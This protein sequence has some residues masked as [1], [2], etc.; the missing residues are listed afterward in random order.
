MISLWS[1][2][3][4]YIFIC[5]YLIVPFSVR[6]G[7]ISGLF[8][9]AM[10]ILARL[11]SRGHNKNHSSTKL[12]WYATKVYHWSMVP[13]RFDSNRYNF[14][15]WKLSVVKPLVQVSMHFVCLLLSYSHVLR[16]IYPN[17]FPVKCPLAWGSLAFPCPLHRVL[18][19]TYF[20]FFLSLPQPFIYPCWVSYSSA[21]SCVS[22]WIPLYLTPSVVPWHV[23]FL[24]YTAS[25]QSLR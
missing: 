4:I 17:R 11:Q 13:N 24:F 22:R 14:T 2:C 18:L 25:A 12:A 15:S 20:R 6:S 3:R 1:L 10:G 23:S 5:E 16:R 9:L 19:R 7:N 8:G 21:F